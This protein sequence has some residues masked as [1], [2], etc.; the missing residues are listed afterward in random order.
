[1]FA[2]TIYTDGACKGNPGPGGYAAIL[3]C[4]GKEKI[5]RGGASQTTNNRMELV[6]VIEGLKALKKPSEVLI[7]TDSKYVMMT[8]EKWLRWQ[9]KHNVPNWD[10]WQT[11]LAEGKNGQHK[12]RFQHVDGHSG[13]VYNERCDKIAKEQAMKFA[14]GEKTSMPI[15]DALAILAERS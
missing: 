9:K 13:H 2:V 6:A 3:T 14:T 4:N 11:L 1:M 7:V 12:I 10:L 5:I 8:R 15:E